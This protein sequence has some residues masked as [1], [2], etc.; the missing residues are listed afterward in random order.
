MVKAKK[1]LQKNVD[2]RV[3]KKFTYITTLKDSYPFFLSHSTITY[4]AQVV[5]RWP[6]DSRVVC[7]NPGHITFFSSTRIFLT[8]KKTIP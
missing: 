1:Y 6:P 8:Q 4:I 3:S 5:A 7:S 2:L